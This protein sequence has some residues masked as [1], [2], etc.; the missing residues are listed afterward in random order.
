[1]RALWWLGRNF[2][3]LLLGSLAGSMGF[4]L[5]LGLAW[6]PAFGRSVEYRVVSLVLVTAL[7]LLIGGYIGGLLARHDP[8]RHAGAVG[9]FFGILAFG[10]IFG[11]NPVLVLTV[12]LAGLIAATGGWL[13]SRGAEAVA[14]S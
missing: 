13:A 5:L 2:L 1:M 7:A 9:I 11:A 10:Y 14:R 4:A 8:V 12:P 6:W 3:V